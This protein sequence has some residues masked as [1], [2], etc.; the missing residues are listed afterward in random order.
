MGVQRSLLI[1]LIC[2]CVSI[3]NNK[4]LRINN[5]EANYYNFDPTTKKIGDKINGFTI[6]EI[7]INNFEGDLAGSI[8]FDGE[9]EITGSYEYLPPCNVDTQD[10]GNDFWSDNTFFLIDEESRNNI[11]VMKQ[12]SIVP[13]V[14]DTGENKFK[15]S[16]GTATIKIKN[17]QIWY[18][19]TEVNNTAE[20]IEIRDESEDNSVRIL[21]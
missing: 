20:L 18:E 8:M 12:Q 5:S 3:P 10:C 14:L 15:Y 6:K 4:D 1:I 9:V 13:I 2:G 16:K 7:S 11:P 21:E 17:Y 19:A